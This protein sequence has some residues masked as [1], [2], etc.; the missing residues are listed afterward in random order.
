MTATE[1]E[2]AREIETVVREYQDY[3]SGEVL[4]TS[5]TIG[6]PDDPAACNAVQWLDLDGVAAAIAIRRKD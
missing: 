4:A 3:I 6:E 2:G 1:G 5:V